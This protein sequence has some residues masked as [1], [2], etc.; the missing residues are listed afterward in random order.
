MKQAIIAVVGCFLAIPGVFAQTVVFEAD[1]ESGTSANTGT[2]AYNAGYNVQT[3]VTAGPD[4]TLGGYVLF[5]D[6]S[7][8]GAA[9]TDIT[10]TPTSAIPLTGGQAAKVSLDFVIRRT[11]GSNKSHYVTGY[12]SGNNIVFRFVLGEL[13]EFGNG[14]G[15]RQRPGYATSG[16]AHTFAG[17]IASGVTP[18]S[19]WFGN[20][21]NHTDGLNPA[22]D[23]H[24]EITVSSGG[25]S[26][27]TVKSD[28]T[29]TAQ[30]ATLPTYD[31]G[32]FSELA[33]VKVT[34]E[35]AAAGGFFDNLTIES[36]AAQ[37]SSHDF[38]FNLA[39]YQS[40]TAD[41]AGSSTPAQFA[42]DGF[43]SQDN[44]WVSS[45]EWPHWLEIEMAVPMAVGSAHL[46]SGGAE[47]PAMA[48]F[49]LQY[50]NGGGWVDIAGTAV[51]GNTLPE[52]NLAFAAP[53]TAQ[54]FRLYT[55]DATARVRELALYPPTPDGSDVAFGVDVDLNIAK[56]RQYKYSSVD[57][58]HYPKLAIDG[59]AD[60]TSAWASANTAGPH[61]LEIHLPQNEN[62]RGIQLYSGWEGQAG[63][64]IQDFEVA[65]SNGAAGWVLFDGGAVSGNTALDL[66]LWFGASAT[67]KVIR[68]RS[69]DS[70]QA[71]IRELVVLPENHT[72]GYP[73]WTDVLDEAPP[74]QGFMDYDDSYYT[75][76]NR[77]NGQNLSTAANG[78]TTVANEPAFQVLLNI[79]TD[80]YRLRSK[81][82]ERCFEV[83]M[84]STNEGAAIVEGTYSSMPHQRW[85]LV[86][87]GDG[88]H[89]RI[90]NVWSGM[91]LGLDGTNVVQRPAGPEVSKQ[92]KI[93]YQDHYPKKGQ[94]S[95]PHFNSMYRPGWSYNWGY[96]GESKF[97]YG[98]YMPMQWGGM[99][100][101]T[102]G[103]LREQP[104]WY[105]RANQTTV[106]G[107][108]EPNLPDQANMIEQTA[109]YQWP[110]MERMRLPLGGPCPSNYKGSWRQNYEAMAAERG[111]RSEYMAMH[112]YSI[113]GAAQGSPGTLINNMTTLHN[114][115]GKPIYLT[116]F[117]TRDFVGD[118]TTWSRNH[119]YNF[120]AEFMWRAET[121]PWLKRWSL[122]E[123]GYG[124]DPDTTDANSE[125][126]TDMNSPKLALHYSND[127]TDP[128]WEDL[129]EC[130]LLMAGW[131]GNTNIV[132]NTAYIIHNKGSFLRL[133]DHPASNSVTTA[134][135][136]NRV[137]TEQFMLEA[138]PGGKKYIT[139]LSDGRR[140]SYNGSTVGL[141]AKGTTG[142]SVEWSLT[143]YQ[144]GW[145]Y[146]DHPSTGKRLRN[147]GANDVDV[148][149]NTT[150]NNN[151]RFRFIK[152]Y[153][154]ISLTEVQTLPYRESFENGV[155]A[156]REFDA[157]YNNGKARFWE[158]GS[159]G[160]PTVAAGPSGASDGEYYLFSE[161]HDAGS[162]VT[163]MVECAFDFSTASSVW[164][165]F[166]YHMYGAYIKF[167][168]LD[169][170][171]GST[172]TSN[173]WIKSNQQHA[174]SD[175]PW[176]KATVDLSAYAGNSSVKLRF[177][178]A[179]KQY[180]AADPAIDN[181][182]IDESNPN[183]P[184]ADPL[185]F[186]IAEDTA[187]AITLSGS[188]AD[189]DILSYKLTSLPS[190]GTLDGTVPNLTYTPGGDFYGSDSFTYTVNDGLAESPEATVSITVEPTLNPLP[191]A[192]SF[193]AG[194][195][196][197]QQ[198][199]A[200]D[201]DWQ[202]N[203][204][205]TPSSGAGPS[206]ASD[207]DWYLY[208]EGH[209]GLGSSNTASVL[210]RFDFSTVA[211]PELTFDYH[212]Y[213]AYIDYLALDV[214]D[215]SSW[216]LDVWRKDGQQH[217]SSGAPW[218]SATV[219]LSAYAG[220]S[221]VSLRFRTANTVWNSADPAIDNI[222]LVDNNLSPYEQWALTA[223]AGA[224]GGTDT[225]ATG[226]PDGDANA[227]R[228][229]WILATDPLVADS[230][231]TTMWFADPT[232]YVIY[233]RR[234]I[235]GISVYAQHSPDL[236]AT[237]WV[238]TVKP[239]QEQVL[240]TDNGV[241]T[242]AVIL[243]Y[244]VDE[245]FIRLRVAE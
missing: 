73:L 152:H 157:E 61:D 6:P 142:P 11:N 28:G 77:S 75:L 123:W 98:Q 190:G 143:D 165:G 104:K 224:P 144:Y 110:R 176:T 65:Y 35:S 83:S 46:Y 234:Q 130:G 229:E 21:G 39:K 140:L 86:D 166:D 120:L 18:G 99:G 172:W 225:S 82:S 2:V 5:A 137:A 97:A 111:L 205:G 220:D 189:G 135:V 49:V 3:A 88:T 232:W 119:N 194:M 244:D 184:V 23:A 173:V 191:Y 186:T 90:V 226:N 208:A 200:D 24:F 147:N 187:V 181:I 125:N 94:A 145:V 134:D 197:W 7:T 138:A 245:K 103:I 45:G 93:N 213:G 47:D 71:V 231:I 13:N 179:N 188:D 164:L 30:T 227:N 64:Q 216:T 178:T 126:P 155:G 31:G 101:A 84:A 48:D 41:S 69:L 136:E 222:A 133:I 29:T 27:Y 202:V 118:K 91:V 40:V 198:V 4:A 56:L 148:V 210:T 52:L 160:T 185:D 68:V 72:G 175:E 42:N 180:N 25:W 62:I 122:F 212:M 22:K 60:N 161:G 63:T 58:A 124:G 1:F 85:R 127:K 102:A 201:Y 26:V 66:D 114:L 67:T 204:G 159:G 139:G 163:N 10:L 169:V 108:N 241:E 219:D 203:T 14:G 158:V 8:G 167:L 230:P 115:Y 15:D 32:A 228:I 92:W 168:A 171:D 34:G 9:A 128:G 36:I 153:L 116:E 243:P 183:S 237:N 95:A 51:S 113:S 150:A 81:D 196:N 89:F 207:G 96:T 33:Y 235:D 211:T 87:T 242:V 17:L 129:M 217:G 117:S 149:N 174:G 37:T 70:S 57:G 74:S 199:V 106:L 80:T 238:D 59:Y 206:G 236:G 221:V 55:T 79:G 121:L 131:D 209:H 156:W 215:G 12:D 146:I 19:Y 233:T 193:E 223:F 76:E 151:V 107:F 38:Y 170:F 162:H 218:S 16:G 182:R 132:D 109:A 78:S 112:W 239:A 154:P 50:D 141:A 195:G 44:R 43:V 20:D 214:F 105:G 53:V 54:K 192:E 177:R 100:S 240:G